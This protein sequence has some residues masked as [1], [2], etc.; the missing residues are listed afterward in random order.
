MRSERQRRS[1][2]NHMLV[3][4][5][6]FYDMHPNHLVLS[7]VQHPETMR[8]SFPGWLSTLERLGK[9]ELL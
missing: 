1:A 4:P 5:G 6:Y 7:F 8:A 9:G 2:E 3:H